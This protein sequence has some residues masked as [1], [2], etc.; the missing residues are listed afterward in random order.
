[1]KS[2]TEKKCLYH[3]LALVQPSFCSR[4]LGAI[5]RLKVDFGLKKTAYTCCK[6]RELNSMHYIKET[7]S[8]IWTSGGGVFN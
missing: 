6:K 7:I 3:F 4:L 2:G 8:I 1:M 5:Q